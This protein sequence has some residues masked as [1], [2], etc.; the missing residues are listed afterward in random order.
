MVFDTTS[1]ETPLLDDVYLQLF[2]S[3]IFPSLLAPDLQNGATSSVTFVDAQRA[4]SSSTGQDELCPGPYLENSS[5]GDIMAPWPADA[6]DWTAVDS[7]VD[8]LASDPAV[9]QHG[10]DILAEIEERL[11]DDSLGHGPPAEWQSNAT[12]VSGPLTPSDASDSLSSSG[13][14]LGVRSPIY[15]HEPQEVL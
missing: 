4:V 6:V 5:N 2:E 8:I 9:L 3:G 12:P 14:T 13:D 15:M 11:V 1:S 7:V 10:L